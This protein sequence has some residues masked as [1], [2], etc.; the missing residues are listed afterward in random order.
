VE[1]N[2]KDDDWGF[3]GEKRKKKKGEKD[4]EYSELNP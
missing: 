2:N 1:G 3:K 4:C